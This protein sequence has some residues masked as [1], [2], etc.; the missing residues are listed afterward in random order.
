M[1]LETLAV[2]TVGV[3]VASVA[4]AYKTYSCSCG[5]EWHRKDGVECPQCGNTMEQYN[6]Y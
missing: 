5:K 1:M 3:V 6:E 2:L 4:E